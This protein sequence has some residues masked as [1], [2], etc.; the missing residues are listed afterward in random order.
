M[1]SK[2]EIFNYFYRN[3]WGKW[4]CEKEENVKNVRKIK[5]IFLWE[6]THVDTKT[7]KKE[8]RANDREWN[9]RNIDVSVET[10]IV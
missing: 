1:K 4:S 10:T 2:E 5:R 6:N 8:R 9:C 7:R 3:F